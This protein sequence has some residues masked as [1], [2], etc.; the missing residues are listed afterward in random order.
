M[1]LHWWSI[2]ISHSYSCPDVIEI[3]SDEDA[4]T[5]LSDDDDDDDDERSG[6]GMDEASGM[7]TND[8]Q[9]QADIFGRVLVNVNRPQDEEEI[10]LPH[11]ITKAVKP[12]QVCGELQGKGYG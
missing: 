5:I 4:V 3:S 8:A 11:Q 2:I 10:F 7:H 6:E 1:S 12:H 9:N